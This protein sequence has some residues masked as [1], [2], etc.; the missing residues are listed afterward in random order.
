MLLADAT[1]HGIGPAL[2]VTQLRAMLRMAVHISPDISVIAEHMN[3]QLCADLPSG[4]FIT[5]WLANINVSK[6]T[7]EYF[8]AGQG[9]LLR[10]NAAL[11]KVEFFETQSCPFGITEVYDT[12]VS[13]P[14][15]MFSGDFFAVISD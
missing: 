12:P 11:D 5:A 10:Y 3:E 9:P 6:E 4:R 14:I 2:S 8:S 1:G 13:D 7:L 15:Q